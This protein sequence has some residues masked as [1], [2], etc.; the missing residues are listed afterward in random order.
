MRR[1]LSLWLPRFATDR[2]ARNRPGSRDKP[3]ALVAETHGRR[4]V[5]A[6]NAPAAAGLTPGMTLADARA[7][8]PALE[9]MASDPPRDTATLARLARWCGRYSPWIAVDR[10]FSPEAPDGTGSVW[11][12]VTGSSH[13]IGGEDALAAGKWGKTYAATNVEEY[14][15]EGVQSWFNANQ[16]S[17]PPN[18]IHNHVSNRD[19]LREYDPGLADIIVQVFRDDWTYICPLN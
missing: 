9:T 1:V 15:A 18:G 8:F 16:Y 11:L 14:W 7:V 17:N 13:L 6:V 19:A 4:V 12:D 10:S 3:L 2:I 5:A